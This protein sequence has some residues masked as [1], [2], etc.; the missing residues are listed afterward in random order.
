MVKMLPI[1]KH[2]NPKSVSTIWNVDYPR[3]AQ[4]A[5]NWRRKYKIPPASED[6][7][8]IC[9]IA[10]DTQNTFCMPGFELFVGGVSGKDAVDDSR[11]LCEFIYRNLS[12][13]T[14][15]VATLDTHFTA[16]VFHPIFFINNRGEHP[17]PY[18]EIS[19]DDI[20]SGKW[21]FN[22]SIGPSLNFEPGFGQRHLRHYVK[23]L[24]KTGRYKLT[25][26]PYHAILGSIGHALVPAFE[27]AVFFH[28]IVRLSQPELVTKGSNPLTEHYSILGPEIQTDPDGKKLLSDDDKFLKKLSVFDVV[29][30]AG[31]AK[32]HCMAWTI[33]DLI[34]KAKDINP[35]LVRKIFILDDCTSS[36]VVPGIVD[37]SEETERTFKQFKLAG[38]NIVKSTE[39]LNL[40]MG[41]NS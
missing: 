21:E 29:I 3:I 37:F 31:Q 6:K 36:V 34:K 11:R 26:W 30:L 17:S 28:S 38:V 23:T 13:I 5:I 32:S 9:L 22:E 39:P 4:N 7:K 27:E 25:I 19:V 18:T 41:I 2:F 16:Q 15:I 8:K 33:A 12:S 14:Q 10:V 1:P 20:E 40:W 24:A 35:M